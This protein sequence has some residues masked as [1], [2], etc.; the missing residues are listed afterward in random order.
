MAK[1]K[2]W[3]M[4]RKYLHKRPHHWHFK[5]RVGGG[6]N[7]RFGFKYFRHRKRFQ[8]LMEGKLSMRRMVAMELGSGT[9]LK[10]E[11]YALC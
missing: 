4:P 5:Y 11:V 2:K 8:G 7:G 10:E 3:K 9:N 6:K 1:G